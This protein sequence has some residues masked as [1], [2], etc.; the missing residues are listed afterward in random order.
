MEDRL[1]KFTANVLANEM[2]TH[3][4][5]TDEPFVKKAATNGFTDAG[6]ERFAYYQVK[7]GKGAFYSVDFVASNYYLHNE[8]YDGVYVFHHLKKCAAFIID[9]HKK[10]VKTFY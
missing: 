2:Q 4:N 7:K 10:K 3:F 6:K 5:L 1:H 9:H 8:Q